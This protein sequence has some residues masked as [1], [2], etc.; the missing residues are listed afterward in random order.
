MMGWLR[1]ILDQCLPATDRSHMKFPRRFCGLVLS[2]KNYTIVFI[3]NIQKGNY[4]LTVL[5]QVLI[6]VF[7]N[8]VLMNST[9]FDLHL[10]TN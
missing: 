3:R 2:F 1:I 4:K 9:D 10:S 8:V 6:Q 5:K 7:L